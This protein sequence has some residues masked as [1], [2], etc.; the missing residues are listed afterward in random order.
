MFVLLDSSSAEHNVTSAISGEVVV[1]S[2][3]LLWKTANASLLCVPDVPQTSASREEKRRVC[4]GR[5]G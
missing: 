4:P 5:F 3:Y 1:K 2:S